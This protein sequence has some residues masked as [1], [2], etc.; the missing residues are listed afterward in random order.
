MSSVAADLNDAPC[1][2][3]RCSRHLELLVQLYE[4]IGKPDEAAK[5]RKLLAQTKNSA[6]QPAKR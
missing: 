6:K 1:R 3:T 2:S 5:W 4:A